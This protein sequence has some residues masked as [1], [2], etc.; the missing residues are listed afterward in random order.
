MIIDDDE[1][2]IRRR[3]SKWKYRYNYLPTQAGVERLQV[4]TYQGFF[5]ETDYGH[6]QPLR[7]DTPNGGK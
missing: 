7:E 4:T 3:G 5:G 6:R 1:A 2:T